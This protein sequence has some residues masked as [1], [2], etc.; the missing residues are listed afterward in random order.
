M[1]SEQFVGNIDVIID[2]PSAIFAFRRYASRRGYA[3]SAAEKHFSVAVS[4]RI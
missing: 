2:I 3:L 4:K 1:Q